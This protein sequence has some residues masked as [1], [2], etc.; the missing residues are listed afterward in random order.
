MKG[1]IV[2]SKEDY[3][4]NSFFVKRASDVMAESGHG[5]ELVFSHDICEKHN[6][7]EYDF[8]IVRTISPDISKYLESCGLITFNSSKVSQI[9][10]NKFH[11]CY[12]AQKCGLNSIPTRFCARF[13]S[14]NVINLCMKEYNTDNLIVKTIDGHGGSEVYLVNS[15]NY[16]Q[17]KND[18]LKKHKKKYW[19]IQPQIKGIAKDVRIYVLDNKPVC[20]ILR[21]SETNYKSNFS[22]GGN[23]KVLNLDDKLIKQLNLLTNSIYMDYAGV[24]FIIDEKGK[25]YFNEIEDVVGARML[26]KCTEYDIISMFMRH[27][28]DKVYD[29]KYNI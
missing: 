28:I 25:Y 12:F 10:N 7:Q 6:I 9:A 3:E 24:D 11:A 14:I 26:Y 18:I 16:S 21:S 27:I 4:K 19:V 2:Y 13:P 29:K 15:Y 8:A 20:G 22:L 17:V 23:V 5:L 1:I